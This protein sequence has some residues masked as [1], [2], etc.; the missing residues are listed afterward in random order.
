[1]KAFRDLDME[2]SARA[3][4]RAAGVIKFFC[5]RSLEV[6]E[7][8]VAVH[9]AHSNWQRNRCCSSLTV[10]KSG[11]HKPNGRRQRSDLLSSV[12]TPRSTALILHKISKSFRRRPWPPSPPGPSDRLAPPMQVRRSSRWGPAFW[13]PPVPPIIDSVPSLLIAACPLVPALASLS[14]R[15]LQSWLLN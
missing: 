14:P 1:M 2:G 9:D 6:F 4:S 12:Y 5:R 15:R 13:T 8:I 7:V 3:I 10:R 11:T